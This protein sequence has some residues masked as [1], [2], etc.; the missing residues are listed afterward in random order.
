MGADDY[1]AK[2]FGSRELIARIR[3]VLRRATYVSEPA[4]Q[5]A[6]Y[7]FDRW[8]LD[9]ERRELL[10]EDGVSVALSSD[11]F[12]L[13]AVFVERCGRALNR[14]QLLDLARERNAVPLD[15][16]IDTQTQDKKELLRWSVQEI[17]RLALKLAQSQLPVE[18]ILRWSIFRRSH[19]AT[20]RQAYL[21]SKTQL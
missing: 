19:Q 10:G 7:R 17:R 3:A 6:R 18:R 16:S 13:L 4:Q 11:E 20:A 12:D 15:R 5:A 9:I 14:E 21:K 2:P 8:V 1:L